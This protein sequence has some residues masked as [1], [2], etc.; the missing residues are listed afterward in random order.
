M[1]YT[2]TKQDLGN[3][4]AENHGLDVNKEAHLAS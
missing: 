2:G 4:M 3:L 1:V